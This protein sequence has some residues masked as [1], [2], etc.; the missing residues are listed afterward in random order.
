M[1][2]LRRQVVIEQTSHIIKTAVYTHRRQWICFDIKHPTF[3]S[4]SMGTVTFNSAIEFS[5]MVN[6]RNNEV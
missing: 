6:E 5:N 1:F 2:R 4:Q 3:Y